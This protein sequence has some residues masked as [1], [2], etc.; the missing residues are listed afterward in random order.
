FT[1]VFDGVFE[2]K[3]N[4]SFDPYA[5]SLN[6]LL[7]SYVIPYI[8]L[9]GYVGTNAHL[10]SKIAKRL[11]CSCVSLGAQTFVFKIKNFSRA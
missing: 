8:G 5:N 10:H 11:G 7:E 9:I 4:P 2:T 1:K 3:L 6:Y